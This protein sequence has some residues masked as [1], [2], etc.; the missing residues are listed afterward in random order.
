[1]EINLLKYNRH[2]EE[3]FIYPYPK[4][5][6]IFNSL[7]SLLNNRMIV[8][9]TG[10]RRV[11]KSTLLFQLINYLKS[12]GINPKNIIYFTFD[13]LQPKIDEI[14]ENYFKQTE[15]DYK[16]QKIY[17]FFDEIQKLPQ[18]QNQL[19]VYYDLYPQIKFV[20]SGST[21]LFIR[22]KTQESLAG[23]LFSLK[24][25][26]LSFQEYLF[27]KEKSE[28]IKKPLLYQK[29]LK[30]EFEMFLTSQLIES[31]TIKD[32]SLKKEYFSS[33]I[34]KIIY[35]DL[36]SIVKF[37]HPSILMRI[38]QYVAQNPGGV[39]NN[40]HLAQEVGVSNKTLA[41]YLSYLED[42]L[43]LKKLYNFSR[44]ITASE[45]RLKKYYLASPS[46]SWALVDFSHPA[47]LF[48]NYLASVSSA[49][50][51]YRDCASH[52]VDF[53][54]ISNHKI[55]VPIEAKFTE[56][57]TPSDLKNLHLFMKK[58]SLKKGVLAYKGVEEKKI[59]KHQKEFYLV[60]FFQISSYL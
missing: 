54:N 4:K 57:I 14:F 53:V 25:L 28:M 23:R 3:G 39:I 15:I 11:G 45:K 32:Q 1:M 59:E 50:Y 29:E 30:T 12:K 7:V 6:E 58:F 41:L 21:S 27:F 38:V 60:P 20:I 2:W 56:K 17:C 9:I 5:R 36:P 8:E 10:L 46:F 49:K 31:I 13:E 24:I 48:E 52:E 43:L 55:I 16:N 44:N 18:F 33:I 26:P 35:E 42:A 19:K 22:K 34:K 37:D 51:F 40:L 47:I